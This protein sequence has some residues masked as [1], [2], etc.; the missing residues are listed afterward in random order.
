VGNQ[1]VIPSISYR[2]YIFPA[3]FPAFLIQRLYP[4]RSLSRRAVKAL[5]MVFLDKEISFFRILP[6]AGRKFMMPA[7]PGPVFF[8]LECTDWHMDS[9]VFRFH[10]LPDKTSFIHNRENR[11]LCIL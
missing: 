10:I 8:P 5:W 4:E 1:H 7:D 3:E 2:I 9:A 6:G 11:G